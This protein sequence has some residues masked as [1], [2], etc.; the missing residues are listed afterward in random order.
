MLTE[1]RHA[2]QFQYSKNILG[3]QNNSNVVNLYQISRRWLS[4][5]LHESNVNIMPA[6]LESFARLNVAG[7]LNPIENT[8]SQH[9]NLSRGQ[10]KKMTEAWH[11]QL[12][13]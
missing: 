10:T 5:V 4:D 8:N 3:F 13:N 12:V 9:V 6:K 2:K 11:H 7:G 1:V